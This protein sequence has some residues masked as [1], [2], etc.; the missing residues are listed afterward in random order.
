M[1]QKYGLLINLLSLQ[2]NKV[3]MVIH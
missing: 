1:K 2:V 3:R